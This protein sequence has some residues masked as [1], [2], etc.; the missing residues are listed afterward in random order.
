MDLCD[1]WSGRLWKVRKDSH[2]YL[3]FTSFFSKLWILS[4]I[5][6]LYDVYLNYNKHCHGFMFI[7]FFTSCSFKRSFIAT[8]I[9][10]AH[11]EHVF[12]YISSYPSMCLAGSPVQMGVLSWL[13]LKPN[14][15]AAGLLCPTD[16]VQ[17]T[18]GCYYAPALFF[19]SNNLIFHKEHV[20]KC[21]FVFLKKR[22]SANLCSGTQVC[23]RSCPESPWEPQSALCMY[24]C[25]QYSRLLLLLWRICHQ[26]YQDWT[27]RGAAEKPGCSEVSEGF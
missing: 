23:E 26:R 3:W 27:S 22:N 1:V 5:I 2:Y 13:E 7:G 9:R 24:G 18:S 19:F 14:C 16:L 17:A 4:N 15:L 10:R 12:T 11:G 25:Q 21:Y 20:F 8:I 6:L